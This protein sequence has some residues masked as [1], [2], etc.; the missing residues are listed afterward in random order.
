[1]RAAIM[2]LDTLAGADSRIEATGDDVGQR[3]VDGDLQIDR[4]VLREKA[5]EQRREHEV[6]RWRQY[7]KAQ[8]ITAS[9]RKLSQDPANASQSSKYMFFSQ[10][11][12][13]QARSD[14]VEYLEQRKVAMR[15][16]V[17]H[18]IAIVVVVAALGCAAMATD[19]VARAG[20]GAGHGGGGMGAGNFG[21]AMGG[22][23][24]GGGMGRGFGGGHLG[25]AMGGGRFGGSLGGGHFGGGH[26]AGRFE[27][28]HRRRARG[29]EIPFGYYDGGYSG[30]YDPSTVAPDE[31]PAYPITVY[32]Y[33][34]PPRSRCSAQTYKVPSEAGGEASINVVRC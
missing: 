17:L 19:A 23:H 32:P 5:R 24:F 13:T 14:I 7:R 6:R 9:R 28:G 27:H 10:S 3:R 21:G 16:S 26:F 2:S 18:R 34:T 1:M 20:G 29:L 31:Q 12:V 4:G 8:E 15:E 22:S 25:G 30:Y 33:V 11:P